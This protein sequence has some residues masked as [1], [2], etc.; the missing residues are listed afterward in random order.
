MMNPVDLTFACNNP[1][2]T[3]NGHWAME[4]NGSMF[5]H[6][7]PP[8]YCR[9]FLNTSYGIKSCLN[10]F[11]NSDPDRQCVCGRKGNICFM[12]TFNHNTFL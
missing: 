2:I 9:C 11:T 5:F 1:Y 6:V 10:M 7:C 4:T 8:G 3:Q 12:Q